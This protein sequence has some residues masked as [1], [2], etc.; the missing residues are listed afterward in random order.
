MALL[1]L[2]KGQTLNLTKESAGLKRVVVGLGWDE[3]PQGKKGLFAPKPEE[4]DCDASAILIGQDGKLSQRTQ[5]R[6][7]G[8]EGTV[9]ADVVFYLNLEHPS[10]CVVH[11]GDNL[12]GGTGEG[13]G[14]D[15]QILV[16][17]ENLPQ[18]FSK[19]VV[20]VTIY[21]AKKKRQHFGLIRNAYIRIADAD[22]NTEIMRYDLS[23]NY[24]A[25]TAM[26]FGELCRNNGGWEFRAI[27]QPTNDGGI[28]DM[29]K[30][31][32]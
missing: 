12:T 4:V 3:V 21:E 30:R 9:Y 10:G 17:L 31:Y 14:D 6:R 20:V 1:I 2:K 27:G 8:K 5:E 19:I 18:Q 24:N 25:Y 11:Q 28:G 7:D 15:E 23:E 13:R 26:I 16:D 29:W 32:M 22:K